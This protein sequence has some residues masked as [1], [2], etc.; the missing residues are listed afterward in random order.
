M[1][2]REDHGEVIPFPIPK[3]RLAWVRRSSGMRVADVAAH[4][5][6]HETTVYRWEK[7][8]AGIPDHQKLALAQLFKVS[9][10]LLMGW[11]DGGPEAA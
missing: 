11:D 10:S 3:N 8:E 2:A 6:L 5:G 9:V 4:L 7:A 1:S